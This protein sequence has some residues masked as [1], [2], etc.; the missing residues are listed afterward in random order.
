MVTCVPGSIVHATVAP[1]QWCPQQ[2]VCYA[3]SI[4]DS[5]IRAGH[6]DVFFQITAPT[7]YSWAALGPGHSIS[8]ADA[9][10]VSITADGK[11]VTLSPRLG[12]NGEVEEEEDE[13]W[14]LLE[15]SG[16][17]EGMMTANVRC[18]GCSTPKGGSVDVTASSGRW[19][20]A[21]GTGAPLRDTNDKGF[22]R[23]QQRSLS[24]SNSFE[25]DLIAARGGSE[26]HPF[27]AREQMHKRAAAPDTTSTTTSTTATS[28]TTSATGPVSCTPDA[29]SA[30]GPPDGPPWEH[31]GPNKRDVACPYGSSPVNGTLAA[32]EFAFDPSAFNRVRAIHGTLAGLAFVGLFPIGGI[33]IRLGSFTNLVWI[34]AGLQLLAYAIYVVA[35]A[36]GIWLMRTL[37]PANHAHPLIGSLIFLIFLSQP[38]TGWLHHRFFVR[39]GRR[40]KAS[41]FHLVIGRAAVIIGILNGGMGLHMAQVSLGAGVAYGVVAALMLMAYI[42]AIVV[43]ETRRRRSAQARAVQSE[44][45]QRDDETDLHDLPARTETHVP[46]Y[47]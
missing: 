23:I 8:E 36:M 45:M 30:D 2:D 11:D 16:V 46:K 27:A 20:Y 19:A 3:L 41:V 24:H 35:F 33:L 44:R 9:L 38:L 37:Q 14:V 21:V 42:G 15:G 29:S 26:V 34:H 47:T 13:Q 7:S 12:A 1:P 32:N 6:G 5:T 28:S 25:W 18:S 39:A 22:M 40:G 10:V 4:P 17:S 43:G 31:H